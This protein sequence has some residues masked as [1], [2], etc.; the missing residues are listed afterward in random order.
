M[1]FVYLV[2]LKAMKIER[3]KTEVIFRLPNTINIDDL[4][5]LSDLFEYK[6][7]AQKS[8]ASQKDVDALVATLKKGRWEKTKSKLGA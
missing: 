5:D 1:I 7:I 2:K 4:Q 8:S 3:T 6:E